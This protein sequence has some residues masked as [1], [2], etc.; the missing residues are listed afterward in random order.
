M[1]S[2]HLPKSC[3]PL[4]LYRI[5]FISAKQQKEG[6]RGVKEEEEGDRGLKEEEEEGDRGVKEEEEGD[7]RWRWGGGGEGRQRRRWSANGAPF[8]SCKG[9]DTF[10]HVDNYHLRT[11]RQT[12]DRLEDLAF[13]LPRA[14]NRNSTEAASQ[15]TPRMS[16]CTRC[17]N[18][19]R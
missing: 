7:G 15:Q 13:G 5:E 4:N 10:R 9:L 16:R 1:L 2:E 12:R 3:S 19:D 11:C 8:L 6:D 18:G 17:K 14:Q